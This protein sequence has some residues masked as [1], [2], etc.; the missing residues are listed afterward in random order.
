[1]N[2]PQFWYEE[3]PS[4]FRAEDEV[5]RHGLNFFR[6]IDK[7]QEDEGL[8]PLLRQQGYLSG[9]GFVHYVGELNFGENGKQVIL[10]RFPH[11]YPFA[12]PEIIPVNAHMVGDTQFKLT[13]PKN[14]PKPTKSFRRGNQYN[15][16]KAC[17]FKDEVDW[18]PF[19]H[20]VAMAL[21]QAQN[22]FIAA[23]SQEGFTKD[24]IV[25][26]N[27][28]LIQHGGQVLYHLP[29][30]LPPGTC[31]SITLKPFKENHYGLIEI[32]FEDNDQVEI[33]KSFPDTA[34]SLS[35]SDAV[36]G[37]WFKIGGSSK[38]LLPIL[39]N[40]QG[41]KSILQ[42]SCQIEVASLLPN[43]QVTSKSTV[44]G[45]M[46]GEELIFHWFQLNYWKQGGQ[47]V[48]NNPYLLG[49]NL[50]K[51]L[52]AR[53]DSLFDLD[54]LKGKKI[55][56]IGA[57]AIGSEV[58]KELAAANIDHF[59]VIDGE[60]FEAG[61]S[62]RHAADLTFVGELKV[63]IARK[64]ITA[65]N[66][67]AKVIGIPHSVLDLPVIDLNNL[68]ASHD[69]VLDLTANRLVEQ[70][71]HRKVVLQAAKPLLQAAVS[72]GALTGIV[73]LLVPGSSACLDCLKAEKAH[74]V[75]H[76]KLDTSKVAETV[77]EYGPCSQPAMPGSG[78]DT[79][80]VALQAA[81]VVLQFLLLGK[82]V[83]YPPLPGYQFYWYGPAGASDR[84]PF[85]WE[86]CSME[87]IPTCNCKSTINGSSNIHK[88]SEA[89]LNNRDFECS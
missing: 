44:V 84:Q 56:A 33:I 4:L 83:F 53:I 86:I 51:E 50:K 7:L 55:L 59:T 76:S 9:Q 71:L 81:R 17:L 64:L 37:K 18:I 89:E 57:G 61:N 3:F 75:P 21:R 26:E 68:I 60:T 72:K 41:F 5:L 79:R 22:W 82:N 73:L 16:D 32:T 74:Y 35:K 42:N 29:E 14:D 69:F 45:L 31:G 12:P 28:P 2:S 88:A 39:G 8:L 87:C 6:F 40:S 15:D 70:Y 48:F 19:E 1:M 78:M 43:P 52:F 54:L 80:E 24:L 46:I 20:G 63:D 66:P 58:L 34:L 27:T 11:S 38:A 85:Q 36:V 10:V 25:D 23:N 77:P 13:L 49:K 67:R 65:R 47:V 30:T 62:V